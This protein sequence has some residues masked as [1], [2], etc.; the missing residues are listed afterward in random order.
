MF[1]E[2]TTGILKATVHAEDDLHDTLS[3]DHQKNSENSVKDS[4]EEQRNP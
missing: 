3:L 2:T 4:P 1:E